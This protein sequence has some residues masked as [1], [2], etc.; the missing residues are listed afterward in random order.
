MIGILERRDGQG[1]PD[2]RLEIGQQ[3]RGEITRMEQ[4]GQ[5]GMTEN[6]E[7]VGKPWAMFILF[8]HSSATLDGI[9]AFGVSNW[10]FHWKCFLSS[11]GAGQIGS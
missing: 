10:I 8:R 7:Q 9:Q 5:I 1:E 11:M 3:A 2:V 4:E 6:R